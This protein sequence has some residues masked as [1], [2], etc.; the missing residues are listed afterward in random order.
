MDKQPEYEE[1][2]T[3]LGYLVRLFS[4]DGIL[5]HLVILLS[6]IASIILAVYS[7]TYDTSVPPWMFWAAAAICFI[8]AGFRASYLLYKRAD[9]RRKKLWD[10]LLEETVLKYALVDRTAVDRRNGA[11]SATLVCIHGEGA[12]NC[13]VTWQHSQPPISPVPIPLQC[14]GSRNLNSGEERLFNVARI[15]PETGKVEVMGADPADVFPIERTCYRVT[16]RAHASNHPAYQDKEF[17]LDATRGEIGF[18]PVLNS[19]PHRNEP[20]VVIPNDFAQ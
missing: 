15:N 3:E 7:A 19:D 20:C 17:I 12:H 1:G 9:N 18:Y 2:L 16:L 5:H 13:G 6:G 14:S 4:R 10:E 11:A 8:M